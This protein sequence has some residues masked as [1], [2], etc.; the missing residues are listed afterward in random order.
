[1]KGRG[2]RPSTWEERQAERQRLQAKQ[3]AKAAA[4]SIQLPSSNL[5]PNFRKSI[6]AS[7]LLKDP[8]PRRWQETSAT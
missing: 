1:M 5:S 2:G 3:A 6:L 7:P 4:R 8:R